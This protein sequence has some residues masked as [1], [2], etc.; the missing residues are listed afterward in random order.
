M[1]LCCECCYEAKTNVLWVLY[2]NIHGEMNTMCVVCICFFWKCVYATRCSWRSINLHHEHLTYIHTY[3]Y[4]HTHTCTHTC[5]HAYTWTWTIQSKPH[6]HDVNTCLKDFVCLCVGVYV[7]WM[8]FVR[9][10]HVDVCVCVCVRN[11]LLSFR[12]ECVNVFVWA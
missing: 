1:C 8:F 12:S 11:A 5:M 4:I 9:Y 2:A 7:L 10:I 6:L 3:V